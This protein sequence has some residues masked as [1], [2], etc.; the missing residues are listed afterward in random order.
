MHQWKKHPIYTSGCP[1]QGKVG[2]ILI[3][4]QGQGKFS[5]FETDL[6]NLESLRNIRENGLFPGKIEIL[7]GSPCTIIMP[8]LGTIVLD[9]IIND[10]AL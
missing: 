5:E 2:E 9:S 10:T 8:L 7:M 6:G 4:F 3:F 1:H